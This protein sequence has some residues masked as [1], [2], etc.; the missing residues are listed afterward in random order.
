MYLL[1]VKS[2]LS[3]RLKCRGLIDSVIR[4][5]TTAVDY[6]MRLA[7]ETHQEYGFTVESI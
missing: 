5:F 6:C 2:K 3:H 4:L 7:L 1:G